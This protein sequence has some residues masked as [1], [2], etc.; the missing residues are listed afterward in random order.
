MATGVEKA[1]HYIGKASKNVH[2]RVVPNAE[3]VKVHR[4]LHVTARGLRSTSAVTLKASSYVGQFISRKSVFLHYFLLDLVSKIGDMTLGL[5][6]TFAPS[7][8]KTEQ[9]V[10]PDGSIE[11]VKMSGLKGIGHAGLASAFEVRLIVG[12]F[13]RSLKVLVLFSKA[14]KMRRNI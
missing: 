7:F 4:G 1:E 3:P 6:R 12:Y 11:T 13:Y 2:G 10:L 9:K 8:G 14:R 5:A